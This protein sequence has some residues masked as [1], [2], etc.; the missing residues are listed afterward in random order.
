VKQFE[1]SEYELYFFKSDYNSYLHEVNGIVSEIF[2][3]SLSDRI[4]FGY[5]NM[6]YTSKELIDMPNNEWEKHKSH[7][8]RLTE[9]IGLNEQKVVIQFSDIYKSDEK[10]KVYVFTSET[11]TI[12]DRTIT[13]TNKMYTLNLVDKNWVITN[14]E[15][16]KYTVGSEKAANEIEADLNKMNFQNYEGQP[17]TYSAEPLTLE[18]IGE[19]LQAK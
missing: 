13:K 15:Q 6:K 9:R 17:V 8:L 7:M 19:E 5:Y 2:L 4:I 11:K 1:K 18:G 14:V 3:D 16:D 12:K 10:S